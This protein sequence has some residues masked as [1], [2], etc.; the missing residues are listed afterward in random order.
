MWEF[1]VCHL[2]WFIWI[3]PL[4]FQVNVKFHEASNHPLRCLSN[5]QKWQFKI[6]GFVFLSSFPKLRFYKKGL[7]KKSVFLP[8][9]SCVKPLCVL[10]QLF[11]WHLKHLCFVDRYWTPVIVLPEL[12]RQQEHVYPAYQFSGQ[13]RISKPVNKEEHCEMLA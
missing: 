7:T 4:V 12:I 1:V 13:Q 2:S 11:V 9:A 5:S 8:M 10:F 3:T 6:K